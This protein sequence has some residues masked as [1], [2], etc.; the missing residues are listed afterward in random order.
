MNVS[1][2]KYVSTASLIYALPPPPSYGR[3]MMDGFRFIIIDVVF[4]E[5]AISRFRFDFSSP[6]SI[7]R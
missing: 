2:A 1:P 5:K 6:P 4:R 3:A 7:F